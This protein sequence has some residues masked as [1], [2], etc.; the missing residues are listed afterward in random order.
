MLLLSRFPSLL[1]DIALRDY[2]ES[3]ALAGFGVHL[4][5]IL[6]ASCA[7]HCIRPHDQ[8][9]EIGAVCGTVCTLLG[10]NSRELGAG[11]RRMPSSKPA[12]MGKSDQFFPKNS[13]WVFHAS[14]RPIPGSPLR[15]YR[16]CL[17]IIG[18]RRSCFVPRSLVFAVAEF[19]RLLFRVLA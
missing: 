11:G 6:G 15:A 1:V 2:Y 10:C 14:E 4:G 12:S 13:F 7:V 9:C 16:A 3:R 19:V 17:V 8:G 18:A 5:Q